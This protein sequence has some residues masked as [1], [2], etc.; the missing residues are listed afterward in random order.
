MNRSA[1]LSPLPYVVSLAAL[2]AAV[3]VRWLL[4]PVLG[5]GIPFIT[6]FAAIGFAVWIGGYRPALLVVGL[7]YVACQYLF[8]QPR[9]KF[10]LSG[11]PSILG[12]FLYLTT[13]S[14]IVI[15]GEAHRRAQQRYQAGEEAA[16]R[17]A[18]LMRTTLA[19]IG[20]GVITTD[21]EGKITSMNAV[22]EELTG[23]TNAEVAGV[24]LTQVFRIVNES[25]RLE[26]E[27][28]AMRAL[29]DG[30]IVG[31]ANHTVLIAKDGSE[32]PVDDSAAPIRSE[33]GEVIGSVLVFRD[34]SARHRAEVE[35]R[36]AQEQI[37]LP[38]IAVGRQVP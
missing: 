14:I 18:E 19:S 20:D 13:A 37:D 17:Q 36:T 15:L 4:D 34:I 35:Q 33:R 10:D 28:P 7:G 11:L 27:N 24:P 1:P 22:A 21:A 5:D 38:P 32:R 31:L 29:K 9:G 2:V 26:V 25:T 3:L 8:I 6:L 12:L 30:V 16:R 23:W